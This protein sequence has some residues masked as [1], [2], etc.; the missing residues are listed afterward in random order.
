MTCSWGAGK[1]SSA[2]FVLPVAAFAFG[3]PLDGLLNAT[4]TC[5]FGFGFGDPLDVFAT[6]A[7]GELFEGGLG[8]LVLLERG[9]EVAG[10]GE[11]H[12]SWAWLS[13]YFD[14]VV[15]ELFGFLDETDNRLLWWQIFDGC[16]APELAHGFGG[17]GLVFDDE[18][19]LPEAEGAVLFEGGHVAEIVLFVCEE[20]HAPLHGFFYFGAGLVDDLAQR[21][22]DRLCK[23]GGFVYVGVDAWIPGFHDAG[24]FVREHGDEAR[25]LSLRVRLVGRMTAI[26]RLLRCLLFPFADIF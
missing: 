4:L 21:L 6:V 12:F 15:I 16:E 18:A 1:G 13:F 14:S 11:F 24:Y 7:G 19:A 10:Y 26:S 2:F 23:L 3:Y 5:G 17:F 25:I 8:F 22:Q 9:R 20:G